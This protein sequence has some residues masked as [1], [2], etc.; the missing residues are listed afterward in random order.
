MISP[1]SAEP[2]APV[3]KPLVLQGVALTKKYDD[4]DRPALMGVDIRVHAGEFITILGPSGC[5]KTTLLQI[6]GTLDE[7]TSGQLFIG[8]KLVDAGFDR[9]GYRARSVG[10]IFQSFHLLPTFTALE[11]V[12]FPMLEM[13]MS[14]KEREERA[15]ELLRLVGLENRENHLPSK[16]S[17]GQ[18]QRVAIARSLANRPSLLLADEPTGN[19]DSESSDAVMALLGRIHREQG[20]TMLMVTHNEEL[21]ELATRQIHMRDGLIVSD[22]GAKSPPSV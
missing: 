17:G 15:S 3:G 6:L 13:A 14:A 11:N 4:A 19:L 18:R 1:S 8:G 22:S 10:F 12:Q 20:M 5:G 7:Q 21:A 2:S 9:Q 16:L